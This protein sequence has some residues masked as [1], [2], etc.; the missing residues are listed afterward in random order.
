MGTPGRGDDLPRVGLVA[1]KDTL[2]DLSLWPELLAIAS[3]GERWQRAA[4]SAAAGELERR[5]AGA[6]LVESSGEA[7]KELELRLL[8]RSEQFHSEAGHHARRLEGWPRWAERVGLEARMA[9]PREAKA[10]FEAAL[11]GAKY[12]W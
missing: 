4:L 12:P 8:V 6:G 1:G 9:T 11:P 7:A 2:V 3:A 10:R 5:V